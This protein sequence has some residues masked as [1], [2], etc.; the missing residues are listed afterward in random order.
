MLQASAWVNWRFQPVESFAGPHASRRAI[1]K[2]WR[3]TASIPGRVYLLADLG[4]V[5]SYSGQAVDE[6]LSFQGTEGVQSLLFIVEQAIQ[7]KVKLS[8]PLKMTGL[9]R[10]VLSVMALS[11]EV[12]NGGYKQFFRNYSRRFGP[13]IVD[14]LVRIGCTEIADITQRPLDALDLLKLNVAEIEA[15][16]ARENVQRNRALKRCDIA[17][18]ERGE[19]SERLFAYVKAHQAGITGLTST[20]GLRTWGRELQKRLFRHARLKAAPAARLVHSAGAHYDQVVRLHQPLGMLGGIAAAHADGQRFGDRFGQAQQFRHGRKRAA[21]V[22]GIQAGDEHLLSAVGKMRR[23][24]DQ[25]WSEKVR[26]IDAHHFGPG[27]QMRQNV[28]GGLNGLR[29]HAQIVMR[30][31]FVV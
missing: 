19:L 1:V 6:I 3:K 25:V 9:E 23:D 20:G 27:I 29:L 5:E 2:A 22:V 4:W 14:D 12:G 16:M 30:N 15:A 24:L 8:G 7:E 28:G 10:M 11:R 26:F 13:A 31:D 17:F 21:H 18:Y